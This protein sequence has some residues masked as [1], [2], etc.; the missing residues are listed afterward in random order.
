MVNRKTVCFKCPDRELGCHD[1]CEKY[2][3]D[4]K[5]TKELIKKYNED[6]RP[7]SFSDVTRYRVFAGQFY[8]T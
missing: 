4:K 2:I 8:R 6:H 3:K 5:E 7:M 1:R